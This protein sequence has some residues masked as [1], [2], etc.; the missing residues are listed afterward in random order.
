M[1]KLEVLMKRWKE[2]VPM[3][4]DLLLCLKVINDLTRELHEERNRKPTNKQGASGETG[5]ASNP[6][7]SRPKAKGLRAWLQSGSSGTGEQD[8]SNV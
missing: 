4:P 2:G 6:T 7:T 3:N 5:E 1:N 8:K